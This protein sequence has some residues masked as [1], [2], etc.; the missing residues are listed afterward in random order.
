[1]KIIK[2]KVFIAF[3]LIIITITGLT[4]CK[5]AKQD[6][7]D[8]GAQPWV[9][10]IEHATLENSYFRI[11]RWTGTTLQMT[12]MSLKPGEEIGLEVHEG[13]DQFIRIEKG[14]GRVLMGSDPDALDFIK[15]VSDDWSIFIPG[16]YWHNLINTG[17][18]ELKLY[19][20]Y[21]PPE[22]AKGTLHAVPA[23]DDH[24]HDH[25]HDH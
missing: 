7:T 20:I 2:S 4:V 14:K 21:A 25:D 23:D 6:T 16:G 9:V 22:H 12:L 13:M 17:D 24:H 1:M 10:D 15:D 8:Y 19:S 11:A 5:S 18:T 3:L